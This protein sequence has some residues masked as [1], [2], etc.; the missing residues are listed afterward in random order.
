MSILQPLIG[1]AAVLTAGTLIALAG[2]QGSVMLGPLPI[3]ALCATVGILLHWVVFIPSFVWQTEHYF[4]LTGG[5]SYLA[6]VGLALLAHPTMDMRG[7]LLC[8]LVAIWAVRLGSFL[9]LRVKRTGRD[10]RFEEIKKCFSRFAFTWTLGGGW[11][12]ITMAAA[13]AAITSE[14]QKPL[15]LLAWV[16]LAL[17]ITG[18][19]VEVIADHQKTR[20]RRNPENTE[21]FIS[22]GLW[23]LSRHPNYLG[24]IVLW[25]GI[26]V[27]AL[28]VLS[29]WQ[30]LTLISPA[31]VVLLLVKVSGV[32]MLESSA[33]KRWGHEPAFQDYVNS[34]PVLFPKIV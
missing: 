2:S 4:D 7:Q 32:P 20:F 6:T 15:G 18:F 26:T 21:R 3:F 23:S 17:W 29:G 16:G 5:L 25:L 24:E 10:R 8:M 9:F 28:P 27:I 30:L 34:T 14:I 1:I 11:V 33:S 12:F 31:F 13:L 19:A 22:T